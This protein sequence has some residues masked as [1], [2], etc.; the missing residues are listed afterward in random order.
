MLDYIELSQ[1]T[2]AM[3]RAH[4]LAV[5]IIPGSRIEALAYVNQLTR[6][7]GM[8]PTASFFKI[9]RCPHDLGT[10]LDLRFY[11]DDEDQRHVQY[12]MAVEEGCKKWDEAVL[13]ELEEKGYELSKER[14]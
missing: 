8:Q 10:Y 12:M 1:T 11:D 7:L 5:K 3:N 9:V 6:I 14:I 13:K 2:R 4:K